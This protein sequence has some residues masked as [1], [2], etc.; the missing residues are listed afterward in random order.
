MIKQ[1]KLLYLGFNGWKLH[2]YRSIFGIKFAHKYAKS[3]G[4]RNR[5]DCYSLNKAY[6]IELFLYSNRYALNNNK[7]ELYKKIVIEAKALLDDEGKIIKDDHDYVYQRNQLR[8]AISELERNN[9][10]NN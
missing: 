5:S 6:E 2:C 10:A 8:D 7:L 1:D 3:F 9:N 4:H